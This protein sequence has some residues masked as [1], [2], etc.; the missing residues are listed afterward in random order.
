MTAELRD[1]L[2][3]GLW[4]ATQPRPKRNALY[5]LGAITSTGS[6]NQ[7]RHILL[8]TNSVDGTP[9]RLTSHPPQPATVNRQ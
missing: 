3:E 4:G 8:A 7:V 5:T 6:T 9:G 1:L 2:S